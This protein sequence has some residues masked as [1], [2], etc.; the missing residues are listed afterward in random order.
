MSQFFHG[1]AVFSLLVALPIAGIAAVEYA[2]DT[3]CNSL[4]PTPHHS[5]SKT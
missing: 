3:Y 1:L 4:P 2:V 5:L